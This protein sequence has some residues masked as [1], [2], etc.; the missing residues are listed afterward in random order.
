MRA[1]AYQKYLEE[2]DR[3]PTPKEFERLQ[4]L[5]DD[6]ANHMYDAANGN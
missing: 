5:I 3:E 2:L 4:E 6:D 1:G